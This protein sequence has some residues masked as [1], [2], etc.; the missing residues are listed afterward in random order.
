MVEIPAESR[1]AKAMASRKL[2]RPAPGT[3]ASLVVFTTRLVRTEP[4]LVRANDAGEEPVAEAPTV[5]LPTAL[6]GAAVMAAR[7][8]PMTAEGADR[9]AKAPWVALLA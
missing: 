7:P 3:R 2:K 8:P 5:S 6:L 9:I 1:L 4:V